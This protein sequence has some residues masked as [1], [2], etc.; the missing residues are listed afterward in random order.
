MSAVARRDLPLEELASKILGVC[1]KNHDRVASI[2]A[3]G[4]LVSGDARYRWVPIEVASADLA[5]LLDRFPDHDPHRVF[6]G[7]NC[8]RMAFR[9]S[10]G[11]FEIGRDAGQ[12]KRLF[13]RKSFWN[14]ALDL[15]EALAPRCERYSYSDRADVFAVQLT[16]AALECLRGLGALLRFSSLE[17]QL[18]SLSSDRVALYVH[19]D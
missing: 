7:A 12:E 5:A 1:G 18:R 15:I 11:E 14:E 19:R 8:V 13:R 9:G 16:P 4:S 2:L 17:A 6:N 10:R 3:R